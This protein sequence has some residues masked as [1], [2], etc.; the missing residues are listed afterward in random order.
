M[1]TRSSRIDALLDAIN[2]VQLGDLDDR[3]LRVLLRLRRSVIPPR[4]SVTVEPGSRKI[5]VIK[6]IRSVL[7]NP[8]KEAK[9]LTEGS[10]ITITGEQL[11]ALKKA[12]AEEGGV[13]T[14]RPSAAE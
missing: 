10:R 7:G 1:T 13:V 2:G 14:H 12:V 5:A 4:V 11:S 3:E 6:A 8:L 9:E